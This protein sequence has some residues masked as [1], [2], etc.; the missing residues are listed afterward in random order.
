M[1]GAERSMLALGRWLHAHGRPVYL[2]TYYDRIG[3]EAHADFPLPTLELKPPA[4]ARAKV[5]ALRFHFAGRQGHPPPI[6]SGYQ[7]AL[8]CALARTGRFHCL[9][10]DTPSLFQGDRPSLKQRLRFAV[11]S[12]QIGRAMRRTG[13]QMIVTSEFLQRECAR[14]FGLHAHIARMGGL[15]HP[16]AFRRRPVQDGLH[17]LSVSPRRGQQAHRLDAGCP[18]RPGA[19]TCPAFRPH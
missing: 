5:A 8:H 14:D 15:T 13:G 16:H 19:G 10:H 4:N 7:P 17:L 1:G 12:W 11:S 18:R 3:L 2:L 6:T 9:M